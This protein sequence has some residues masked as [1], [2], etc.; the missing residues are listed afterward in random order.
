MKI[1]YTLHSHTYRCGHA[2]GDI[3]DYVSLAVKNGY[4]IY[5]VSDHVFLPG[6]TQ[7]HTRGDYS[8]LDEYIEKYQEAKEKYKNEIQMYLGFECEY[9]E[10][11]VDYYKYLLKEKGFDYLI[12]GQHYGFEKNKTAYTYLG[13]E[14]GLFRYKKDLFLSSLLICP[15][16]DKFQE[17][18]AKH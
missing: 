18:S 2:T 9:S 12:C 6:I 3:L 1:D 13:T 11:F 14:E 15:N 10:A 17:M 4:K 8:L 7:I 16:D 5:G